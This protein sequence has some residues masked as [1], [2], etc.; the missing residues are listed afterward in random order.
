MELAFNL[1]LALATGIIVEILFLWETSERQKQIAPQAGILA[2]RVSRMQEI[3]ALVVLVSWTLILL[4]EF[5]DPPLGSSTLNAIADAI[6]LPTFMFLFV[7]GMVYPKLMPRINEQTVVVVTAIV[8]VSLYGQVEL[9]PAWLAAPLAGIFLLALTKHSLPAML[10]SLFYFW[11]LICLLV[12]TFLSSFD[13]L[14]NPEVDFVQTSF[15]HFVAGAAGVFFGLHA[16]FLVRFFLMLSANLLPHN[17]YLIKL[18]M[19]QL[20]SDEQMPRTRFVALLLVVSLLLWAN[21]QFGL[22]ADISLASLL[23]L[24]V[25]HFMDRAAQ[26]LPQIL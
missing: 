21:Q 15:D 25:V 26:K 9:S 8:F 19:P 11:Y 2:P 10:K 18:A 13:I 24:F 4:A 14:F 7:F 22:V 3:I 5:F 6:M 17:R 1:A 12:M 20:F 23:I 16:I